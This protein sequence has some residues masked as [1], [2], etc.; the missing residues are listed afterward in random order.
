[1]VLGVACTNWG[2]G[3]TRGRSRALVVYLL[4]LYRGS[5]YNRKNGSGYTVL[6]KFRFLPAIDDVFASGRIAYLY[7]IFTSAL[8][9]PDPAGSA[10][11]YAYSR[12]L[13]SRNRLKNRRRLQFYMGIPCNIH[14]L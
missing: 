3:S 10:Y 12:T 6:V 13:T 8:C 1:M 4:F 14:R 2:R 11:C 9:E 5:V 7:W